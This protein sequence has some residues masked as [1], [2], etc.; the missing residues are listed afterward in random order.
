M[1]VKKIRLHAAA[2]CARAALRCLPWLSQGALQEHARP[3]AV[4]LLTAAPAAADK[5]QPVL[6]CG[7]VVEGVSTRLCGCGC[8][9]RHPH[10]EHAASVAAVWHAAAAEHH[11][12][13]TEALLVSS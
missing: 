5:R 13:M 12:C 10:A 7:C 11:W 3:P 9:P 6:T 8:G 1:G 4:A 2:A